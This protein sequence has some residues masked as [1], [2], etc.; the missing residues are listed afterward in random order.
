MIEKV[1]GCGQ[2]PCGGSS[3]KKVDPG[4]ALERCG[5]CRFRAGLSGVVVVEVV[6]DEKVDETMAMGGERG[7]ERGW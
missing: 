6:E 1:G 2:S 4:G 7:E 5:G 3:I